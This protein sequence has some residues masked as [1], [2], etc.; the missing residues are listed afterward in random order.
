M[1]A[2]ASRRSRPALDRAAR[3][4]L[5]ILA[6]S[7]FVVSVLVFIA[8]VGGAACGSG[9][10][11]GVSGLGPGGRQ[12]QFIATP[13]ATATRPTPSPATTSPTSAP[14]PTATPAATPGPDKAVVV[15]CGNILA[16]LDKEHRLSE[17]CVPSVTQLD[18]GI[19][20]GAQYLAPAAAAALAE[21]VADAKK[22]GHTLAAVSGYRSYQDQVSTFDYWVRTQGL[23]YAERSS[24][25]PGHSEHQ[26]G[27]TVD[28]S[29][30]GA[31][32]GLETFAGTP[33]AKWLAANAWK[34]GFVVSYPDGKEQVTGYM[35]EPWHIRFVGKSVAA[36]VRASGLTLHEYLLKR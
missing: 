2:D 10:D 24:A 27:T 30:P 19:S 29:S 21:L 28:V 11:R 17:D 16:P 5:F 14:S 33:E 18:P 9:T 25:R 22:A 35:P 1:E 3:D 13:T 26:L 8:L 34:F 31:S 36:D 20:Q 32:F 15:P 7:A 4:P 12:G 6:F 23:E